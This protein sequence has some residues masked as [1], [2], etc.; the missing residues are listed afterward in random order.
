MSNDDS[1]YDGNSHREHRDDGHG[2]SRR[3]FAADVQRLW[4]DFK[5]FVAKA[6]GVGD[7]I[8][9]VA[10]D[11]HRL[12]VKAA[13][14]LARYGG[15]AATAGALIGLTSPAT[16]G[17]G[18]EVLSG[19]WATWAPIAVLPLVFVGVRTIVA[20]FGPIDREGD[21]KQS[22]QSSDQ[23]RPDLDGRLRRDADRRK[24]ANQRVSRKGDVSPLENR[25]YV[26]DFMA[27][28]VYQLGVRGCSGTAL[29]LRRWKRRRGLREVATRGTID[30]VVNGR[31]ED[32]GW[33]EMVDFDRALKSALDPLGYEHQAVAFTA[34]SHHFVLIAIS[35]SPIP[36]HAVLEISHAATRMVERYAQGDQLAAARSAAL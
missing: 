28:T 3:G 17:W 13:K 33:D 22:R 27:E 8:G 30:D 5:Q 18:L 23:V 12:A 1:R 36:D 10:V 24:A 20:L 29:T 26:I 9:T 19:P 16:G 25:D 14:L 21:R 6:L 7:M 31:L 34:G 15:R 2:D 35:G 4:R 11:A 32:L